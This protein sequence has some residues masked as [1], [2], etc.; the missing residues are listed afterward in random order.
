[1]LFISGAKKSWKEKVLLT[2][3]HVEFHHCP[4][5]TIDNYNNPAKHSKVTRD[6]RVGPP[7]MA[8][9][10]IWHHQLTCICNS[11]VC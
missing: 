2:Y 11:S 9:K 4:V 8:V 7:M 5:C 3:L 1:M 6:K 10:L